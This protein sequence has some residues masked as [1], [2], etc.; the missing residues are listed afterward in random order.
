MKKF[1]DIYKKYQEY[2]KIDLVMYLIMI[3]IIVI[4]III[5]S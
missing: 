5:M 1:I 4:G 3:V 2:I